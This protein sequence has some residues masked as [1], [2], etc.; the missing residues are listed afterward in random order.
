MK[1]WILTIA[2]TAVA[3]AQDINLLQ[4]DILKG[5][6]SDTVEVNLNESMLRMAAGFMSDND[7]KQAEVKKLVVGVKGIYVRSFKF[8]KDGQYST[9]DVE[10]LRTQLKAAG[11]QSIV[12]VHSSKTGGDNAGIYMH[13]DGKQMTGLVVLA[14]E[15]KELTVVNISGSIDPAQI[16]ALSGTLGIPNISGLDGKGQEK[17]SK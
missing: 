6:A 17:K 5:R 2:I 8:D 4:F 3:G 9:A 13:T 11:W 12:D 16:Q 14:F 15:P 1:R 10:A 7:A